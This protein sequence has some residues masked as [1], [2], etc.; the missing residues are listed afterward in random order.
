MSI[1]LAEQARRLVH[2]E[3]ILEAVRRISRRDFLPK[4]IA[5]SADVDDALPIGEG[6]T[7]SQPSLVAY[8]IELLCLRP[9]HRVLEVGTGCGYQTALL[10]ELAGEVFSVELVE[11]L[12]ERARDVLSALGYRNIRLRIGDGSSGWPEEAPFD[13]IIV[14][15]AAPRVPPA[16]LEELKVGGRLAV[17]LG[18][19]GFDFFAQSDQQLWVIE[20]TASGLREQRKLPVRFVPLK[21]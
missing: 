16:L 4:D 5:D 11:S 8:M 2:D 9:G 7:S 12:G 14:S 10:A 19:S 20:K 17:P 15:C 13:S 18:N 6:Q 1:A 3:R 21:T